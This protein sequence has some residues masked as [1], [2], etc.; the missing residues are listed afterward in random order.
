M[1]QFN[2][3]PTPLLLEVKEKVVEKN[4]IL[5]KIVVIIYLMCFG[6][7]PG[8]THLEIGSSRIAPHLLQVVVGASLALVQTQY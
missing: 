3:K 1:I 2:I 7:K 6:C 4:C 5:H 8:F